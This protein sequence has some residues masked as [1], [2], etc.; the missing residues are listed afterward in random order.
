MKEEVTLE[1]IAELI[2]ESEERLGTKLSCKIDQK[3]D[4]LQTL[5]M[6]G[7]SIMDARFDRIENRLERME[8]NHGSRIRALESKM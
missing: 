5:M 1:K 8:V 4:S 3:V 6:Q 7:F 2:R